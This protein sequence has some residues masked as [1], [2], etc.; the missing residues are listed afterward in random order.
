MGSRLPSPIAL[1]TLVVS[2]S[3][4]SYVDVFPADQLGT[5]KL[6]SDCPYLGTL[7]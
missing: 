7:F 3:A 4:P 6:L 5:G 2:R 1:S